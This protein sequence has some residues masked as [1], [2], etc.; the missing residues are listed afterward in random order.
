MIAIIGILIALLLPA[1]QAAREA[2][3][4][5]QCT[6]QLKQIGL[7]LHTYHDAQKAF[8]AGLLRAWR[9]NPAGG[10]DIQWGRFGPL[11]AILPYIE[12]NALF[13]KAMTAVWTG[14]SGGVLPSQT[15]PVGTGGEP[16]NAWCTTVGT[17][18]CP[19]SGFTG[20]SGTEVQC[21]SYMMCIVDWAD[22]NNNPTTDRL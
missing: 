2:A 11:V 19:S 9:P 10:A 12:Q 3:R 7:A 1:V 13:D 6:N 18:L 15:T 14:A 20:G 8:P 21:A 22:N 4:R 16:N 17:Y 5:M